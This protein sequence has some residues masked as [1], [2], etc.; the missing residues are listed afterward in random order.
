MHE[1]ESFEALLEKANAGDAE[2][3]NAVGRVIA[4]RGDA[5]SRAESEEWF[6]RAAEQGL[7]RA[8][9]N[10]GVLYLRDDLRAEALKWF[11]EAAK[12]GWMP[13]IFAFGKIC[14][15]EGETE[16]AKRCFESAAQR[17]HAES[18]DALGRIYFERDTEADHVIARRWSEAAAAQGVAAAHTRLGT[19]YHEGLGTP[20]D[21]Q[22]AAACFL[23]GANRGH[24]GSQLMI[25]AAF[26]VGAGVRRD[27]V[28]A[29]K[30]ILR[31]AGQGNEV[32]H[33]YVQTLK[34]ELRPEEF[35]DA[36]RRSR[37]PLSPT[38]DPT[39]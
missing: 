16:G 34:K 31:S 10:L 30:W 2:A 19:I 21:P 24:A 38:N 8:K 3:Q 23:E 4:S 11:G 18:Q 17:G 5:H 20:R 6:R 22:R 15:E 26:D 1:A 37:Q 28:E 36:V 29:A 14:E 27:K 33:A 39:T 35:E 32:A 7:P 25:G 12:D 13:S 9:H